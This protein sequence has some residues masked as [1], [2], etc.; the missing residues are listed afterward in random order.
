MSPAAALSIERTP[1]N[2]FIEVVRPVPAL[3]PGELLLGI[4]TAGVCG[5]DIQIVKGMR[6][7]AATVLGHEACCT[8]LGVGQRWAG[9]YAEG[10]RVAVN[11]TSST[12]SGFLLGH[13]VDGVWSSHLL[14]T[15]HA[16]ELG[17]VMPLPENLD[18]VLAVLVEPL[19]CAIYSWSILRDAQV[20]RVVVLGD[21]VVGR[22]VAWLDSLHLDSSAVVLAGRLDIE[23]ERAR[24]HVLRGMRGRTGVVIAT[25]R[26]STA[27]CVSIALENAGD[28]SVIDIIGGID[29]GPDPIL[30]CAARVRAQNVCGRPSK[31]NMFNLEVG[32]PDA[33]RR[34]QITG[35]RGVSHEH[36]RDAAEL[37]LARGDEVKDLI[38]HVATPTEAVGA[39]N[40]MAAGGARVLAGRRILKL[41][42]D[43]R[44]GTTA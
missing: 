25:P 1:G 34:V 43:F 10:D 24:A 2:Q 15:E 9:R 18:P 22:L 39:L 30:Q 35:H 31:P 16:V 42:I 32:V 23:D 4:E 40:G 44:D 14:V 38:T 20:E 11:P 5:T 13:S 12:D 33:P 19:A 21:G 17:Q 29:P 28:G 6:S 37:L 3:A 8:V 36:F 7:E 41:V 27:T 26:D